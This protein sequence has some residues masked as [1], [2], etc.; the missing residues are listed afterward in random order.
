MDKQEP[1]RGEL[2]SMKIEQLLDRWPSGAQILIAHRM[3]CVGCDFAKFHTTRQA[4]EIYD[5]EFEPFIN[6]LL[7]VID[8]HSDGGHQPLRRRSKTP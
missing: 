4:L 2:M 1:P 6:N 8:S 7:L 5:L 3:A